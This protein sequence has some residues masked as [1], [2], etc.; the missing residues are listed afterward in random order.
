LKLKMFYNYKAKNKKKLV[1]LYIKRKW[2]KKW[3][4]DK[5]NH[6]LL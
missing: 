1:R 5:K 6:L 3:K 4:R 2:E